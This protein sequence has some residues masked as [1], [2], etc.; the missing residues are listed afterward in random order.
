MEPA[1]SPSFFCCVSHLLSLVA[2]RVPPCVREHDGQWL[3]YFLSQGSR[4]QEQTNEFLSSSG[5]GTQCQSPSG[6]KCP[7]GPAESDVYPLDQSSITWSVICN[8]MV[9]PSKNVMVGVRER[10]KRAGQWGWADHTIDVHH[11]VVSALREVPVRVVG[12]QGRK[13]ELLAVEII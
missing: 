13:T 7:I 8:N 1:L 9:A 3:P 5:G 10:G 12:Y 2:D 4:S 11:E 6:T